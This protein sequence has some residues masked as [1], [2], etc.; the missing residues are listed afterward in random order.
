MEEMEP[1]KLGS[2]E[3]SNARF[4]TW[5][6]LVSLQ[7]VPTSSLI[8]S[9]ELLSWSSAP[10]HVDGAGAI[11]SLYEWRRQDHECAANAA[12]V[13]ECQSE[14]LLH[15]CS[16]VVAV[17]LLRVGIW[18]HYSARA[19]LHLLTSLREE[20]IPKLRGGCARTLYETAL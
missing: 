5:L 20:K 13:L 12:G 17:S 9:R 8:V 6:L 1:M 18:L 4:T 14:N 15:S 3:R 19:W 11:C 16:T 2:D 10:Y 7:H